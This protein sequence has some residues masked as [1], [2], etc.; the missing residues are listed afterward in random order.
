MGRSRQTV[1]LYKHWNA[2][3]RAR[4]VC[5]TTARHRK[6]RRSSENTPRKELKNQRELPKRLKTQAKAILE[7]DSTM[8]VGRGRTDSSGQKHKITKNPDHIKPKANITQE[9]ELGRTVPSGRA[10]ERRIPGEPNVYSL[11]MESFCFAGHEIRIRESLDSYGALTWP[12]AVDLCNYLEQNGEGLGLQ[13]KAVLEL[14]AGTGLVS[15]VAS[16]MGAWVT[17]TDV[18]GVLNNLG[19]NLSRNTRGRSRYTPQVAELVWGQELDSKFPSAVYNYDYILCA[20][21]VYHHHWLDELLLTMKYFCRRGTVLLW[22]NKI[23]FQSD[24]RFIENFKVAFNTALLTEIPEREVRIY[25]AMS[26]E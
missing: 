3:I 19:F 7:V 22:A 11:G 8:D 2:Q 14:G 9:D 15:I 25:K 12:G 24:L 5:G 4:K 10:L 21:I 18:P 20:D 23:R 1:Q 13:D 16:L 6:R 26:K 17:A